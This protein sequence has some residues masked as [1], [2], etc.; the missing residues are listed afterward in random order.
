MVLFHE[1]KKDFSFTV[2]EISRASREME[3]DKLFCSFLAE[4][5][6]IRNRG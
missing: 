1:K 2:T 4:D 6:E 5:A 3:Q